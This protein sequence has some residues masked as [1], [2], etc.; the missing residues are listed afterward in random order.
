MTTE[1]FEITVGDELNP[2]V[3]EAKGF[4]CDITEPKLEEEGV[5]TAFVVCAV[6]LVFIVDCALPEGKEDEVAFSLTAFEVS[7]W[8]TSL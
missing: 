7:S 3:T 2:E 4:A 1:G 6:D 8:S 5:V